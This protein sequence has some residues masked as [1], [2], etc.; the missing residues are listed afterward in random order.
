[1][2]NQ[3]V[4]AVKPFCSFIPSYRYRHLLFVISYTLFVIRCL[5][6]ICYSL[7]IIVIIHVFKNNVINLCCFYSNPSTNARPANAR[8]RR[9][10]G[11]YR[12]R[13]GRQWVFGSCRPGFPV[14]RTSLNQG[15]SATSGSFVFN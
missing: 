6:V 8:R 12:L 5:Y 10:R 3:S 11:H 15:A 1:M 4:C 13:H 9:L 2:K 14:R 7:L